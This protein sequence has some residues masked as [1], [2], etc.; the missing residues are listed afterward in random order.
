MFAGRNGQRRAELFRRQSLTVQRRVKFRMRDVQFHPA[1]PG[2]E[3]I[4]DAGHGQPS[5]EKV[6]GNERHETAQFAELPAQRAGGLG[7]DWFAGQKM[8]NVLRHCAGGLIPAGRLFLDGFQ[9]NGPGITVDAGIDLLRRG[10]VVMADFVQHLHHAVR[11]KCRAP[12]EHFVERDAQRKNIRALI[13]VGRPAAGLFRRHVLRRADHL[14]GRRQMHLSVIHFL[15]DAEVGDM[16]TPGLVEKDVAG[17]DVAMNDVV[18]VCV[19]QRVGGL[20]DNFQ[21]FTWRERTFGQPLSQ[22][23][24]GN[25]IHREIVHAVLHAEIVDRDNVRMLNAGGGVGF[26]HEPLELFR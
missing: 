16:H 4:P 13:D 17:F 22:R 19:L 15:R 11:Q 24:A 26:L 20:P 14:A 2:L 5:E 18:F 25:V 10:R 8:L 23:F 6:A 9:A 1:R 3:V 12:G 7:G 21:R